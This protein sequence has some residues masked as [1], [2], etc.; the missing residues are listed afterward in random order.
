M[1]VFGLPLMAMELKNNKQF[2]DISWNQNGH[3]L[4]CQAMNLKKKKRF[5]EMYHGIKVS[6]HYIITFFYHNKKNI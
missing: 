4:D 6:Y 1:V 5:H 3:P 2:H